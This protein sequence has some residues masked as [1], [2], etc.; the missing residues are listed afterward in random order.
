MQKIGIIRKVDDLGRIVIPKELRKKLKIRES[1]QIL[2]YTNESDQILL[3]KYQPLSEI[4][5]FCD[6]YIQALSKVIN[7]TCIMTDLEKVLFI[8]GN[9]EKEYVNK[10]INE[11][12]VKAMLD[13]NISMHDN[14][15]Y[16][17]VDKEDLSKVSDERILPIIVDSNV[18][19]AIIIITNNFTRKFG[20]VEEKFLSHAL[21]F[22]KLQMEI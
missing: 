16:T 22:F 2:I 5:K 14:K 21:E 20:D 6:D 11:K 8:Y 18:V 7:A 17:I 9:M 12:F 10:K 13:R 19:G 3:E 1:E 15:K 4:F